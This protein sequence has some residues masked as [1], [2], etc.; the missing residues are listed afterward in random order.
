MKLHSK[1]FF[2]I[3]G[4]TGIVQPSLLGADRDAGSSTLFLSLAA[5]T[6]EV[7]SNNASI[8]AAR[9]KWDAMKQRIPQARAWEDLR[10]GVDVER[11]GTTRFDKF[12]DAEWTVSQTFPLS[13]K[14]RK[15]AQAAVAE[16]G[17]AFEEFRRRELD[18]T[19]QAR[20]AY[21]RLANAFTQLDLNRKNV[22][23]L[24]QLVEISRAKYEVGTQAQGDV[25]LGET[26][27]AK[28]E[29]A[30]FD[31]EAQISDAQ[32]RLNVLMN[33]PASAPLNRPAPLVAIAHEFPP[34]HLQELALSHRPEMAMAKR[35]VEAAQA[36]Y[37]LAKREWI[38]DPE[39]RVEARQY[40][41]SGASF[42]EYDT[43]IFF[44]IPWLNQKKYKA[45]IEEAKKNLESQRFELEATKTETLG[46]LRD[47]LKKIET[48][49][50]HTELFRTKIVPLAQ[51][52]ITASRLSYE[53]DKGG[54]LN[55]I[56]AQRTLQEVE[57]MYWHHLTE[58]LS[59]WAELEAVMGANPETALNSDV[60]SHHQAP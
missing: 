35:K 2:V 46:Q 40:N 55:V 16:A 58:Y 33:R 48:F 12:S 45:A 5:V 54:F 21:Y 11:Y 44:N 38:P 28:Q 10:A 30:Q 60:H 24:Q 37:D 57:S 25:L 19:V 17:V 49:H 14:N 7:L 15:R 4:L 18:M 9:A 56:E 39:F 3:V 22:Q 23:L 29:E 13:G 43:G 52:N 50:H 31:I 34:D 20:T 26:A 8:K 6:S 27:L 59:A 42:Q 53:T 41:G 32:S 1:L 36:R 51:Q 47:H